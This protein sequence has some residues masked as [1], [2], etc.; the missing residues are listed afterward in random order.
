MKRSKEI[1]SKHFKEYQLSEDKL[2]N[3]QSELL[4]MLLDVKDVCD[5]YHID[6]MLSGGTALGAV[7]HKGFIPWDDDVDIMML[8]SEYERFAQ[9][10]QIELSEKY[11]LAEPLCDERYVNKMVKLYKKGTTYIEIPTA[12]INCFNML[13][14]DVFLIE[15]VPAPGIYRRLKANLY[16]I[17]FKGASVCID[18][19][20]PSPVILEKAETD[21]EVRKYYR[22]RRVVGAVF[23]HIGGMRFYL[24]ICEKLGNQ[25]KETGWLGIPSGISYEREIFLSRVFRE[26]TVIEFCGNEFNIPAAYDEYLTNLYG[27]YMQLPPPE[28][29]EYHAAYK[30]D[31]KK[32]FKWNG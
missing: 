16:N 26:L 14:L 4:S 9:Y 31:L 19:I 22:F 3:L 25:T 6:Y 21:D 8:R 12:G 1:Y 30:I 11:V 5:K 23:A 2:L 29:R 28:A 32:G 27:D 13:F 10:F 18:Y 20:Y 24:K 7:R 15:N 17:A